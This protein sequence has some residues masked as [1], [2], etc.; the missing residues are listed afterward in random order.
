MTTD[1]SNL[2]SLS[3]FK[4]KYFFL[5][6]SDKVTQ[7][8]KIKKRLEK[9]LKYIWQSIY[10][11]NVSAIKQHD[12]LRI[13]DWL[14]TIDGQQVRKIK[15]KYVWQNSYFH[16]TLFYMFFLNFSYLYLYYLFINTLF[17]IYKQKGKKQICF[18]GFKCVDK[19]KF[20]NMFIKCYKK[21]KESTNSQVLSK[22]HLSHIDRR[23]KEKSA[24]KIISWIE[25]QT[26]LIGFIFNLNVLKY[27]PCWPSKNTLFSRSVDIQFKMLEIYPL[28][29]VQKRRSL[30]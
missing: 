29:M 5:C 23:F 17:T 12:K 7:F 9:V 19:N 27:F 18:K 8:F 15:R 11:N 4:E 22:C 25:W 16:W 13:G 2:Q 28:L 10:L 26:H 30:P 1:V 6:F 3:M 14:R 21:R 20:T 24:C